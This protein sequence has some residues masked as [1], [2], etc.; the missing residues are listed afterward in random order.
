MAGRAHL[1]PQPV[2]PQVVQPNVEA[3]AA[4]EGID[5]Q[6]REQRR[7]G[8]RS[9]ILAGTF[10]ASAATEPKTLLGSYGS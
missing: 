9:T 3:D 10:D 1:P 8:R 4:M 6:R 5:R 7:R 2:V